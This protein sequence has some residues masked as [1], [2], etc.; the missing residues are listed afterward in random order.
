LKQIAF[1]RFRFGG[2]CPR[3]LLVEE[4]LIQVLDL[5][6]ASFVDAIRWATTIGYV[7]FSSLGVRPSRHPHLSVV[8]GGQGIH[9]FVPDASLAPANEPIVTGRI[10]AKALRQVAPWCA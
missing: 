8:S 6:T 3:A 7:R 4:R 10:G 9:E 2:V 5:P 1:L